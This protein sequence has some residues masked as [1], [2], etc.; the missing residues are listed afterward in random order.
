M[1]KYSISTDEERYENIYDSVDDAVE[2]ATNGYA[3]EIFWVGE[4]VEP[5]QPETFFEA[6]N[7]LESVSETEDYE[8]DWAEDWD[9][10]TAMQRDELTRKVREV[11]AEWLDRHKLRPTH[12]KITKPQRY[13]VTAGLAEAG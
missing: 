8:G 13:V 10:S 2:E 9:R 6:R 12:F 7:W 1:P 3:Y 4:I 5:E 11:M